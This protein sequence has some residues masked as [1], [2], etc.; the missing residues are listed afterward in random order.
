MH[1]SVEGQ[2]TGRRVAAATSVSSGWQQSLLCD[3]GSCGEDQ[4]ERLLLIWFLRR[5][6]VLNSAVVPR[7]EERLAA[8][9]ARHMGDISRA[10]GAPA[11]ILY[12]IVLVT[13]IAGSMW[14]GGEGSTQA[15]G[16]TSTGYMWI[17]A[18]LEVFLCLIRCPLVPDRARL[19][20]RFRRSWKGFGHVPGPT[21]SLIMLL[22]RPRCNRTAGIPPPTSTCEAAAASR[23]VS[24]C[25][26]ESSKPR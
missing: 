16:G 3:I 15:C 8:G 11:R 6:L 2:R 4:P 10:T 13:P 7:P 9:N 21:C 23:L 26:C 25:P 19:M 12:M 20:S 18:W 17:T 1:K 22:A 14:C 24:I 5:Q